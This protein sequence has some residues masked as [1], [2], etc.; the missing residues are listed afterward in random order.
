MH[1]MLNWGIKV[2]A[3]LLLVTLGGACSQAQG[4]CTDRSLRGDFGFTLTGTNFAIGQ[5]AFVGGF[6]ADGDGN[7]KGSG[8]ESVVGHIYRGV[9]FAGTYTVNEDCSGSATLIFTGGTEAKLDFVLVGHGSEVFLIDS[10]EGVSE[11]GT[12]KLQDRMGPSRAAE[13]TDSAESR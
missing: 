13:N 2:F 8:T 11:T 4:V 3:I 1:N 6:S 10:D 5:F 12:A 7:F 9:P